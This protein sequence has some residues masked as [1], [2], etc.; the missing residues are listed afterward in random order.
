MAIPARLAISLSAVLAA[1]SAHA[2]TLYQ[3]NALC[4]G[5]VTTDPQA[6]ASFY[7]TFDN[8][9]EPPAL[10]DGSTV[11]FADVGETLLF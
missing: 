7:L 1:T 10:F 11:T 4:G 8:R 2:A 5:L 6:A 3:S 9:N